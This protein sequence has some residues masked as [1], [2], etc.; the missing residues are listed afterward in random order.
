MSLDSDKREEEPMAEPPNQPANSESRKPAGEGQPRSRAAAFA[1]PIPP[2]IAKVLDPTLGLVWALIGSN[3]WNQLK[4]RTGIDQQSPTAQS[5]AL[6][7]ELAPIEI[8]IDTLQVQLG[9][10]HLD[11]P[12]FYFKELK[13]NKQL[14]HVTARIALKPGDPSQIIDSDGNSLPLDDQLFAIIKSGLIRRISAAQSHQPCLQ[15]S[16]KDVGLLPAHG[17]KGHVLKGEGVIVGIID[18]GCA[19]AHHNFL[20]IVRVKGAPV[21]KTRVLHLWDQS[22]TASPADKLSGWT[23]AL[24]YG[25]EI[26]HASIDRAIATHVKAGRIDDDA[27]Y[28]ELRYP[29]G[30]RGDLSSHGTHVMDIAAGNGKSLMGFEGI[31]PKADIV[32]V[33]LPPLD[34]DEPGPALDKHIVDAVAYIFDKAGTKPVVV[35]IS[36]G[37]HSGPHDG[38]SDWESAIDSMLTTNNRAV[39][40]SAGNGFEADC[41]ACGTLRSGQERSLGLIVKPVDPTYNDV[42]I[43]YDGAATLTVSLTEPDTG[44]VY[45]PYPLGANVDILQPIDNRIIGHVGHSQPI[46]GSGDSTVLIALRPTSDEFNNVDFAAA[47]SGVWSVTLKNSGAVTANFDAWIKRDDVG[48]YGGR[49]QQ[50]RFVPSDV[51]PGSTI[52]DFATGEHTIAVGAYNTGTQEVARY[53]ACGPTRASQ[54]LAARKKPDICAPAEEDV[55]GEGVLS[56]SSLR[57]QPTRLSGTSASA[58]HVTGLVALILEYSTKFGS[59]KIG[60]DLIRDN[61]VMGANSGLK[62]NRHQEA[63][64]RIK[65]K[66]SNLWSDVIGGGKVDFAA[67][68]NKLFP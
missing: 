10:L 57:A 52:G 3:D 15:D 50:S 30:A 13:V 66:Q 28:A 8:D 16:I 49:R 32:F 55:A 64:D 34:I 27:V 54:G 59:G 24:G 31:A 62:Y 18:D 68:M 39:V 6:F 60:A 9:N 26:D 65:V 2:D 29:L 21:Y 46:G 51:Y 19:F 47:R 25:R 17:H 33:Q 23:D 14:R 36:Y 20:D 44:N 35:N 40:V 61:L 67:A 37:G 53:S 12:E 56:A 38:T 1:S 58:P 4:S 41:H 45:G 11:V 42:E 63:D 5:L 7:V 22:I 43:W 48:R